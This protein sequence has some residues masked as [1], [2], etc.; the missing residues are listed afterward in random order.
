MRIKYINL[1]LDLLKKTDDF[2]KLT[3]FYSWYVK[4]KKVNT[5]PSGRVI[6]VKSHRWIN[7]FMT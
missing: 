1:F 6:I 4:K 3:G 2:H 5:N 7:I